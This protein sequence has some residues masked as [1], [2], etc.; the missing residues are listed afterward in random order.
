[1]SIRK[2]GDRWQ[3]RV[4]VGGGARIER[5]LPAGATRAD[6]LAAEA[7][8]RRAQI[9]AAAGRPPRY[10]IDDVL[11]HWI[12]TSAQRLRSWQND[13]RYRVDVLRDYVAGRPLDHLPQ[14][15]EELKRAGQARG[16][17]AATV[18]RML[19]IL[20]RLGNLAEQLGWTREPLGRRIRLLPGERPRQVYLTVADVRRLALAA[21]P[22]TRDFILFAALTGLRRSEILRLTT[23]DVRDG[24][25]YVDHRSKS[26]RPRVVPLVQQA[27][28]IARRRIPFAIGA[29]LLRKRFD[30]ARA[31]AGMPHVRLHDLRHAFGSWL[32]ERGTPAPIIRELMGHSSLAVTSRYTHAQAD[33]LRAAVSKLGSEWGQA[34]GRQKRRARLS[35]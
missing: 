27:A 13:L 2:R 26:G 6:A 12:E 4:R 24:A 34:D 23:A 25:V 1:M 8:I 17:A 3:V 20:R 10:L 22:V 9:D 7:A 15:A 11:R 19:A 14:V 31:A 16:L 28:A 32:A 33:H 18:N 5:T 29:A 30:A 21:E 35:H